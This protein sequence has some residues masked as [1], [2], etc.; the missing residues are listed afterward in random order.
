MVLVKV[1]LKNE[2]TLINPNLYEL[3]MVMDPCNAIKASKHVTNKKTTRY[4]MKKK[5]SIDRSW[6]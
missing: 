1:T 4:F 5:K 6:F 2:I 3:L